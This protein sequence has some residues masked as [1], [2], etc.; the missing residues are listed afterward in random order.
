M[1]IRDPVSSPWKAESNPTLVPDR[2]SP[3]RTANS[4]NANAPR[5]EICATSKIFIS[6]LEHGYEHAIRQGFE[7]LGSS[8][9]VRSSDRVCIKPNL[10]FPHFRKGV[11]TNPEALEALVIY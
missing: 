7:F 11:M 8:G 1:S 10:T 2:A 4:G 9:S 5:A 3:P 6:A